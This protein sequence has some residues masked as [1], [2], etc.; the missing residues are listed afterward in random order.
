MKNSIAKLVLFLIFTALCIIIGILLSRFVIFPPTIQDT[1]LQGFKQLTSKRNQIQTFEYNKALS[2]IKTVQDQKEAIKKSHD[3]LVKSL[4]K[5]VKQSS[6]TLIKQMAIIN[7]QDT[8]LKK[9]SKETKTQL[10][11]VVKDT[12]TEELF[13]EYVDITEERID[14]F[15]EQVDLYA[16]VIDKQNSLINGLHGMIDNRDGIITI[17]NSRS[18]LSE[19]RVKQLSKKKL[20][21]GPGI[22]VGI[23]PPTPIPFFNKGSNFNPVIAVG[24]TISFN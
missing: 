24:V 4:K 7:K 21:I 14:G 12:E 9:K 8:E 18:I 23:A 20:R 6:D 5:E 13:K 16:N 17:L 11:I 1:L 15:Q 3:R 22:I 10:S 2:D 19:K